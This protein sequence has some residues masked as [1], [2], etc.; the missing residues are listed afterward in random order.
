MVTLKE[1][2]LKKESEN[3]ELRRKLTSIEDHT[4]SKEE[5]LSRLQS[6][7]ETLEQRWSELNLKY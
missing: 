4:E 7:Q 5:R 3:R 6:E 2:S 1:T